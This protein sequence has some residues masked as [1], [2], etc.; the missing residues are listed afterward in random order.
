MWIWLLLLL[1]FAGCAPRQSQSPEAALESA[2]AL[3]RSEEYGQALAAAENGLKET[4]SHPNPKI[5]WQFRLLR[6]ETLLELRKIREAVSVLQEAGAPAQ[7]PDLH[8]R[9]LLLEAHAQYR[10][11]RN[12]AAESSLDQ[13]ER[14]AAQAGLP[15]LKAEIELRRGSLLVRKG[16]FKGAEAVLRRVIAA[17]ARGGDRY[18]QASA[19]GNLG[20]TLLNAAR[21]DEALTWFER[22]RV[23]FQK[24]GGSASRGR[25]A[26]NVGWCHFRLGDLEKA[27]AR[28]EE[29]QSAFAAIGNRYEE[30]VWLGNQGS[31]FVSLGDFA[32]AASRYK[33]ALEI[34]REVNDPL[35]AA[36]W[37]SNLAYAMTELGD[38]DAA[39]AYNNEARALKQRLKDTR[40]LVY[41][42][43]NSGRIAAGRNRLSEAERFF[44]SASGSPSDDPTPL[45]EAHAG[46]AKVYARAGDGRRSTAQYRKTLALVEE[47]RAGIQT[48]DHQLSYYSSLIRFY[49]D[50]ID[51]LMEQ[52]KTEAAL[53]TAE[54]SRARLLAERA[55]IPTPNGREVRGTGFRELARRRDAVL[56]SYWLGPER[57]FLWAVTPSR[58]AVYTL[59]S[60]RVIR[61]LVESYNAVILAQRN[62][63]EVEHPAGRKLQEV[64]ISPARELIA[65]DAR[66]IVVPDGCL[67]WLNFETLP[68]PG[69][70]PHYWIEDV[71]VAVT[72]S[73][74]LLGGPSAPRGAGAH[75]SLLIIGDPAASIPDFPKLKFA[76]AE[77]EGLQ[78]AFPAARKTV[79]RGSAAIPAA[80]SAAQP[81]TFNLIHF[82]AHAIAN[83]ESPLD[84][85]VILSGAEE[86]CKLFAREIMRL[87]LDAEVVTISACRSAGAKVYAG[88][89]PV[90]LAWAFLN[91]GARNVIAGLW[92]VDDRSTAS[93]MQ[94]FYES[95]AGGAA[96]PRALRIAKLKLLQSGPAHRKPFYWAPFQ[97][98]VRAE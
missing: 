61:P 25:V 80:Y 51:F 72:P 43:N 32:S 84:S 52:G 36:R 69:A 95:I 8:A 67:H 74:A 76:A 98:Y 93:L 27:I 68:V 42:L 92:N 28:F 88:E 97:T 6:A 33:R 14:L 66:V 59:P 39:E 54:S 63:L 73:L 82:A 23:Q 77:V 3:L 15:L 58:T 64:L 30:Q 55:G 13:S 46:L 96:P 21:Y 87:P 47:Q 29:A 48:I 75:E 35:S 49:Q 10:L 18:L 40:T 24:T 4:A 12:E 56:L 44:R 83:N 45:L 53:E 50:Y 79:L 1:V 19:T 71:E 31:V 11:N 94:H 57:S 34:A 62:P 70:T 7:W 5:H 37:L 91:A 38:F 22:A 26:G 85:A 41:V 65:P 9:Y 17:A 78:R 20:F 81:K 90:G 86:S 2:R 89:G 60:E 16:D